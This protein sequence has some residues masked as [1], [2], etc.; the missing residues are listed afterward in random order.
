MPRKRSR[1]ALAKGKGIALTKKGP[2]WAPSSFPTARCHQSGKT[3][4]RRFVIKSDVRS[5]WRRR[6][7]QTARRPVYGGRPSPVGESCRNHE[8]VPVRGED[9]GPRCN[10]QKAAAWT[11][12]RRW[13]R[14]GAVRQAGRLPGFAVRDGRERRANL[15]EAQHKPASPHLGG[16]R[17]RGPCSRSRNPGGWVVGGRRSRA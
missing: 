16:G 4:T 17:P 6:V 3:H 5:V 14:L 2:T 10:R 15:R 12:P 11:A 8:P 13:P 9:P 1:P 7:L